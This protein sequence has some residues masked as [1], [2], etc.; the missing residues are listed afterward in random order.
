MEIQ[1]FKDQEII[2]NLVIHILKQV[3]MQFLLKHLVPKKQ[4]STFLYSYYIVP[5]QKKKIDS[6]FYRY[7]SMLEFIAFYFLKIAKESSDEDAVPN[8]AS[9]LLS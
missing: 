6:F 3:S 4:S 5:I 1:I 8:P 2:G 7:S 9:F